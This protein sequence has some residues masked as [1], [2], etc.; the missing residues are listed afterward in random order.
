VINSLQYYELHVIRK[1]RQTSYSPF[2]SLPTSSLSGPMFLFIAVPISET[3][4]P[5]YCI[6]LLWLCLPQVNFI[7][8]KFF[9]HVL[10][11]FFNVCLAC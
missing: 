3:K 11:P 1:V 8:S 10:A 4:L 5:V 2:L 6:I 7:P 9:H